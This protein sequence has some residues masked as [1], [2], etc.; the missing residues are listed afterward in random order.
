MIQGGEF[1]TD[2]ANHP[3]PP[4]GII[5]LSINIFIFYIVP[6]ACHQDQNTLIIT[7]WS[8]KSW[9][10]HI[11][12]KRNKALQAWCHHCRQLGLQYWLQAKWEEDWKYGENH[13]S[14]HCQNTV[15]VSNFSSPSVSLLIDL[16]TRSLS[17]MLGI[18]IPAGGDIHHASSC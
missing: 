16:M 11:W 10:L 8:M 3:P 7:R 4:M 9:W 13:P 15:E 1:S 17:H 5:F 14:I 18:Y 6:S 2:W 12:V